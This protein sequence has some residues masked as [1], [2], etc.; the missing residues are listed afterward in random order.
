MVVVGAAYTC[1]TLWHWSH[2]QIVNVIQ[3]MTV[4]A[5]DDRDLLRY[6]QSDQ[7]KYAVF[8]ANQLRMRSQFDAETVDA[9]MDV[10]RHGDDSR[11]ASALGYLLEASSETGVDHFFRCRDDDGVLASSAKRVRFLEALRDT[12]RQPPSDYFHH[13]CGWIARADS[14][15]EV[16]LLLSLL[17]RE[18]VKSAEAVSGALTLLESDN[19]VVVR[20]SYRFLKAQELNDS[21]LERLRA[22]EKQHPDPS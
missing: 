14:Y 21:Q 16:H 2:G 8:A 1:F 12:T 11:I 15:Y 19:P 6:L 10:V 20:R 18:H 4:S 3:D 13:F 22:F 7:S 9:V 17:E 5:T